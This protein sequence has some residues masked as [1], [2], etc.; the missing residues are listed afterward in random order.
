MVRPEI[1]EVQM[2]NYILMTMLAISSVAINAMDVPN[3][4]AAY[5]PLSS[6]Y[7]PMSDD[8]VFQLAIAL[9]AAEAEK[10]N[11]SSA[12]RNVRPLNE[13]QALNMV[14]AISQAEE[15]E[16][17]YKEKI[18]KNI[19]D[20]EM[21]LAVVLSK[22]AA[23]KQTHNAPAQPD[24]HD[25][26]NPILVLAWA[27]KQGITMTHNEALAFADEQ[28]DQLALQQVIATLEFDDAPKAPAKSDNTPTA[29]AQVDSDS[30]QVDSDSE[31][32]ADECF[33]CTETL[34]ANVVPVGPNCTHQTHSEC[35]AKIKEKFTECPVCKAKL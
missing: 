20:K 25:L 12:N 23:S 29:P 11:G 17:L 6:A 27:K 3:G 28:R 15:Q 33:F 8:E 5:L 24:Q 14:L 9:S 35:L 2:N 13:E 10:T 31:K 7:T 19:A 21:E 34:D 32:E 4:R 1:M 16:R 18:S 30:A 22:Q 26:T